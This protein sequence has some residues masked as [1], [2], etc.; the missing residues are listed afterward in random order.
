M[1]F[2][3]YQEIKEFHADNMKYN[4][5]KRVVVGYL[6]PINQSKNF[7]LLMLQDTKQVYHYEFFKNEVRE[8]LQKLNPSLEYKFTTSDYECIPRFRYLEKDNTLYIP[9][10]F[11]FSDMV[12]SELIRDL[13]LNEN[14][15]EIEKTSGE[16]LR[17]LPQFPISR[18]VVIID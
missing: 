13:G 11:E 4:S 12:L 17:E 18:K 16:K 10:N 15:P 2:E 1:T 6:L 5:K 8:A 14:I 3:E 7:K 9:E